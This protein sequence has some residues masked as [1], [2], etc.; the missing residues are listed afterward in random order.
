MAQVWQTPGVG[1]E[2]LENMMG[3]GLTARTELMVS[4]GFPEDIAAAVAEHQNQ[5]MITA[6]LAL[7]RSAAQPA[8]AEAGREL[9]SA[10]ARPGLALLATADQ[11]SSS[12]RAT[13]AAVPQIGPVPAPKCLRDWG[14]GG[15]WRTRSAV[16]RR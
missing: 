5:D 9:E 13:T 12:A 10:S 6:I 8:M 14:I 4:F 16:P 15:C 2:M 3:G 7:Y 11:F 1:E